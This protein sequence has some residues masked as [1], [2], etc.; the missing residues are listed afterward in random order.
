MPH[1]SRPFSCPLGGAGEGN[2]TS[3][4][5]SSLTEPTP[6]L[7][8]RG[9]QTSGFLDPVLGKDAR[10]LRKGDKQAQGAEPPTLSE[11]SVRLTPAWLRWEHSLSSP[12]LGNLCP[13]PAPPHPRGGKP[14]R[15]VSPQ[16]RGPCGELWVSCCRCGRGGCAG[17]RPPL[18]SSPT[19]T[20]LMPGVPSAPAS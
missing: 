17:A 2:L 11:A 3:L 1:S 6:V 7:G 4:C 5:L 8:H 18:S 9:S 14:T 12:I 10:G 13:P 20:P 19:R 15:H 16:P